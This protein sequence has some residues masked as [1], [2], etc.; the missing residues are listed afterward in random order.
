MKA[1]IAFDTAA[2]ISLGHVS[3]HDLILDQWTII[4]TN[5]IL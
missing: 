4:I 3:L 1:Q 2:L 5:E